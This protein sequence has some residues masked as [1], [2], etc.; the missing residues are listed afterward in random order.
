[1]PKG[2]NWVIKGNI[3]FKLVEGNEN[4]YEKWNLFTPSQ[5]IRLPSKCEQNGTLCF[6]GIRSIANARR[7]SLVLSAT[8]N[9]IIHCQCWRKAWCELSDSERWCAWFSPPSL[10]ATIRLSDV[11]AVKKN[12]SKDKWDEP[13]QICVKLKTS[14]LRTYPSPVLSRT[15]PEVEAKPVSFPTCFHCTLLTPFV[16]YEVLS[17]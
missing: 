4:D 3:D 2:N 15:V 16:K 8:Q 7:W 9:E 12:V 1:M 17:L 5:A 11:S 14:T 13:I 10:S 6:D